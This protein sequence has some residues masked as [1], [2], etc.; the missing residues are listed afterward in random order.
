MLSL[1]GV[2]VG[3]IGGFVVATMYDRESPLEQKVGVGVGVALMVLGVAMFIAGWW[4]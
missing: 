1:A 4:E 3:G 2:L